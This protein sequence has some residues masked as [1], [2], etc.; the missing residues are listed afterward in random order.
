MSG[1]ACVSDQKKL[2]NQIFRSKESAQSAQ[3]SLQDQLWVTMAEDAAQLA[4]WRK[5]H[6][7]HHV[8]SWCA[9]WVNRLALTCAN[10]GVANGKILLDESWFQSPIDFQ[11]L[12]PS[13]SRWRAR[14]GYP[15]FCPNT[16]GIA[17]KLRIHEVCPHTRGILQVLMLKVYIYSTYKSYVVDDTPLNE[18]HN[19]KQWT[20]CTF[21]RSQIWLDNIHL[22]YIMQLVQAT[23]SLL[24]V[25]TIPPYGG[26]SLICIHLLFII[27]HE[28]IG[29]SDVNKI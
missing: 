4:Q 14:P 27:Y 28:P 24:K 16:R 21:G 6:C 17:W 9:V 3:S 19:K 13:I 10:S 5:S 12:E 11:S 2:R 23:F 20:H 18:S 1:C 29:F 22:G 25:T 8:G 7:A 15:G 26:I